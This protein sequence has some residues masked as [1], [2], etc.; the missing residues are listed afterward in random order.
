MTS[1]RKKTILSICLSALSFPLALT[2]CKAEKIDY[3]KY[4]SE[5][6]GD[7]FL[8]EEDGYSLVAFFSGREYPYRADGICATKQNLVEV[9]FTA[10][11]D[12][13][14]YEIR[15]V[16]GEKTYGGE[17]SYDNVYGRFFYSESALSPEENAIAFS[18]FKE[19]REIVLTAKSVKSGKELSMSGITREL[20]KQK[21]DYFKSISH[22][23]EFY[24]EIYIRLVHEEKNYYFIR[25]TETN[26][27]SAYFFCDAETGGIVAE[28]FPE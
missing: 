23:G 10:P 16:L 28:R 4:V 24:G 25:I 22:G 20:E 27:K 11:D 18:I 9:F 15:F 13:E 3:T 8:A 6:R 5:Y 12:T 14:K 2:A 17:A 21:T 1:F 7:V 19:E 26:G